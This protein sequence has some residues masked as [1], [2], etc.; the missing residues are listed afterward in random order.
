MKLRYK[1][2]NGLLATIVVAVGAFAFVLSRTE[3]CE[4]APALAAGTETMKAIVY[5]CYGSPDVLT[6]EEIEKPSPAGDEVLVKVRAAAVNPY[7]WH[8]MRGSPYLMR[9]GT[10]ITKALPRK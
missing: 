5:R 2:L 8:H 1:I 3:P 10:G 6:L 7:D 4:P 9:L